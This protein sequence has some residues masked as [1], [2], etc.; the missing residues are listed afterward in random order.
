M[1]GAGADR[2]AYSRPQMALRLVLGSQSSFRRRLL[3][4]AGLQFECLSPDIDETAVLGAPARA[5]KP[6]AHSLA[7]SHT[8]TYPHVAGTDDR[9]RAD[10]AVLTSAI[11]RAKVAPARR[12][13]PALDG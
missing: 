1:G 7:S 8:D 4:E 2:A 11:A 13:A 9:S 3:A 5:S 12:D 10:P 6:P